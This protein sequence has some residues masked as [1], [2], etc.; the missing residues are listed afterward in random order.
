MSIETQFKIKNNP[1][2]HR[3]L[4]ENS[5]WYKELN[6]DPSKIKEMEEEMKKTYKMTTGDKISSFANG[7]ELVKSLMDVL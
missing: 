4:R 6:R 3:Y 7:I 1:Y 5:Y 2:L